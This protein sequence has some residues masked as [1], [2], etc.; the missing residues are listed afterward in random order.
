MT[1]TVTQ[2]G[3]VNGA[4]D[5]QALFLKLF[6][7]EVYEAF[8]NATIAKGLVMNRTLKNGR[9]AQFIHT[10][11]GHDAQSADRQAGGC[12]RR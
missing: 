12:C 3:Q 6:T 2:L 5:T 7:G 10:G 11:R 8:R 4:G 1:A 9:E